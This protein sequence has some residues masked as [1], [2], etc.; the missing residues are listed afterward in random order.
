MIPV[1]L[2][3]ERLVL[4]I[5]VEADIDRITLFCQD[6]LF[7]RYLT[8]PW[9]YERRHAQ[10]FV[11]EIVPSGWASDA[12]YTWAIRLQDDD[13][14]LGVIGWRAD[15]GDVGFWMGAPHRGNGYMSEALAT[16]C[17]WVFV[18]RGLDRVAWESVWGNYDSARVAR[19]VGFR[20]LGEAPVE[21]PFRDGSRPDGWHAELRRDDDGSVRDGWPL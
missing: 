1:T 12:E 19:A 15:R 21:L 17:E 18:E 11:R 16:V 10:G 8:T 5:P 6:P 20:F 7:E 2:S 14:L 4:S 13:A 3:T 9:P